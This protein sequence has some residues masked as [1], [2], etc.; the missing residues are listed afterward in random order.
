M[1]Q[2]KDS[3]GGA[4]PRNH[5]PALERPLRPLGWGGGLSDTVL[6]DGHS[7]IAARRGMPWGLATLRRCP[8]LSC[9]QYSQSWR[10]QRWQSPRSTGAWEQDEKTGR[11]WE[12][13]AASG[14]CVAAKAAT[15][16]T[17]ISQRGQRATLH[18]GARRPL[19]MPGQAAR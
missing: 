7:G 16:Q 15:A 17:T 1:L 9:A 5:S 11:G 10:R 14:R 6:C 2:E 3:T 18:T 13:A 8:L 4:R 19:K 12:E